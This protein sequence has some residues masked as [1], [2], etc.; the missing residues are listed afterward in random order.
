MNSQTKRL[1]EFH[2]KECIEE[3]VTP[4]VDWASTK[5]GVSSKRD[6]ALGYI[7]AVM[8]VG[9]VSIIASQR[10]SECTLQ[11]AMEAVQEMIEKILPEII[12]KVEDEVGC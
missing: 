4:T 3:Q 2:I 9:G 11:D 1:I 7:T 10:E 12:K 5:L 8:K 6:F